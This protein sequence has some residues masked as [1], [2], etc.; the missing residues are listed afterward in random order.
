M[1]TTYQLQDFAP[2]HRTVRFSLRLRSGAWNLMVGVKPRSV[3]PRGQNHMLHIYILCWV[4]ITWITML[5]QYT[6]DI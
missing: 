2:I 1:F 6:V 3:V 5:M 4:S